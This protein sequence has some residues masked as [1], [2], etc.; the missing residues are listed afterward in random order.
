[1][2]KVPS[3]RETVTSWLNTLLPKKKRICQTLLY[4]SL[5]NHAMVITTIL[6]RAKKL[7]T[8]HKVVAILEFKSHTSGIL[9][10]PKQIYLLN[11]CGLQLISSEDEYLYIYNHLQQASPKDDKQKFPIG[12]SIYTSQ[13]KSSNNIKDFQAWFVTFQNMHLRSVILNN[14]TNKKLLW[15]ARKAMGLDDEN[16]CGLLNGNS[17]PAYTD[18]VNKDVFQ[19]KSSTD[20]I[21]L[22]DRPQ[23]PLGIASSSTIPEANAQ[24]IRKRPLILAQILKAAI[25]L[26]KP[27]PLDISQTIQNVNTKDQDAEAAASPHL[28]EAF[29][30]AIHFRAALPGFDKLVTGYRKEIEMQLNLFS[31]GVSDIAQYINTFMMLLFLYMLKTS[32]FTPSHWNPTLDFDFL[33]QTLQAQGPL[34]VM[35]IWS[36]PNHESNA[37]KGPYKMLK[38]F[39]KRPIMCMDSKKHTGSTTTTPTFIVIVGTIVDRSAKRFILYM[40]PIDSFSSKQPAPIFTMPYNSFITQICSL[41]CVPKYQYFFPGF[42][43]KFPW[44]VKK[45][46]FAFFLPISR[47]ESETARQASL[48]DYYYNTNTDLSYYHEDEELKKFRKKHTNLGENK[49]NATI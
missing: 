8:Q 30:D 47:A 17:Q 37:V 4:S 29:W 22:Y 38:Q 24:N 9:V 6:T 49:S 28:P 20:H 36:Y 27:L 12:I 1:M 34:I 19:Q 2:L 23:C 39:T 44:D 35:G 31:H 26:F 5:N 33:V 13:I 16:L 48:V 42:T 43:D 45:H 10:D 7:A 25:E 40:D 11:Y 21:I 32:G 15:E 18:L 41:T 3:S 14:P 46:R